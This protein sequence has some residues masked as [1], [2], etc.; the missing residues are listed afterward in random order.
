MLKYYRVF[1]P[2]CPIE[3][4]NPYAV[5]QR[6]RD[7]TA[8]PTSGA[9]RTLYNV[10]MQSLTGRSSTADTDLIFLKSGQLSRMRP[11]AELK[12]QQLRLAQGRHH[13]IEIR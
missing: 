4:R 13:Y 1:T 6:A 10:I 2:V 5:G 8:R 11:W 9:I 12:R 3:E 7:S